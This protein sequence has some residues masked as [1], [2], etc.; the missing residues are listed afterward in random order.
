[1][2]RTI[3]IGITVVAVLFG[4]VAYAFALDA[5]PV[6]QVNATVK[7]VLEITAPAT[8]DLGELTP[9]VPASAPV[10]INAK[11]NK[12]ATIS[13]AVTIGTFDSLTSVLAVTPS[14]GNRGGNIVVG[15][16]VEGSVNFLNDN[17]AVSGSIT[18]SITQP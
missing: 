6:T 12:D 1:M 15:D 4:V 13:S 5:T 8:V 14:S 3:L 7:N 11:S 10:T 9:D 2:K 16:T 18:Y 17:A